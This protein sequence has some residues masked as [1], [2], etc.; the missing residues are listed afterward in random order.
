MSNMDPTKEEVEEIR[1]KP[2]KDIRGNLVE[3]GDLIAVG[4]R[5]GNGGSLDLGVVDSFAVRS[6]RYYPEQ[7][8]KIQWEGSDRKSQI[9][10][11]SGRFVILEK[12]YGDA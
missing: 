6:P 12:N 5:A 10:A 4:S 9:G 1:T 7:T 2:V 11:T 3:I 8:M